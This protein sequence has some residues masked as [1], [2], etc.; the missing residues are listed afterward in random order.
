MIREKRKK[1]TKIKH[2]LLAML[3]IVL[4]LVLLVLVGIY[5]FRIKKVAVSGNKLYTD[6]QIKESVLND[7]YSWNALYVYGKY[8][9]FQMEEI[10]FVDE[11]EITLSSPQTLHINVYEKALI[12]YLVFDNRNVYFDKDGFVVE[13]SKK[14]IEN[15]PK[16]EG[17]ECKQVVA[18]EKLDIQ[19]EELLTMLLA[20]S[21]QLQKYNLKPEKIVCNSNGTLQSVFGGITVVTGDSDYLADKILRLDEILP[22]LKGKTGTLHLEHWTPMSTDIVFDK[23]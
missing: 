20:L 15:I 12:G 19:D 18:Y 7:E 13:I 14:L 22:K 17:L 21:R 8:R 6:D 16:V 1:R 5:G 10:P 4:L 11:L 9:F 23:E 3:V 2:I